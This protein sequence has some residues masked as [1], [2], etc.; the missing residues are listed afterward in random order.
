[1]SLKYYFWQNNPQYTARRGY[2][3]RELYNLDVTGFITHS[4]LVKP[5]KR[6]FEYDRDS[7]PDDETK[8]FFSFIQMGVTINHG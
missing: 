7:C 8:Q 4:V 2:N 1:M 6:G 3:A 5:W